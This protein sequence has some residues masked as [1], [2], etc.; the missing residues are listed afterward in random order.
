[1]NT[2]NN[3]CPITYAKSRVGERGYTNFRM[4]YRDFQPSTSEPKMIKA[5]NELWFILEADEGIRV[6]SDYGIYDYLDEDLLENIHEHADVISIS[7]TT[8]SVQRVQFL[9]I[10]MK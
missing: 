7:N 8:K 4:V 1:M 5:F 6:E 9:Q 10:I 3:I 2:M